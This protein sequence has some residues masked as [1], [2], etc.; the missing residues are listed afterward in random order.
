[1]SNGILNKIESL[2]PLPQ[3]IIEIENYR[4]E[5]CKDALK[6]LR[7]IE[8][9]ALVITTLLKTT[10]SAMFGFR[11]AVETPSR[12][13]NLLGINFTVSIAIASIINNLIKTD[14]EPYSL[15]GDDFMRLSNIATSLANIWLTK[16]DAELRD[17]LVLPALLQ[18][19]GK[20][21]IADVIAS[22]EKT[23][24]FKEEFT[25]T[26]NIPALEK[27]MSGY[28]T[29]EVTALVFEHWK[30]SEKLVSSIKYVDDLENCDP[31]YLQQ[32]QILDVIKTACDVRDPL[33][34]DCVNSA[35]KKAKTYGLDT[36][37]F[38]QAVVKLQERLLDEE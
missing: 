11:S 23:E 9:D 34:S 35:M 13:I 2:P 18:E 32:A 1:M 24:P 26:K 12:A 20:F 4:K 37:L 17:E 36:Q 19:A 31:E 6:L 22:N 25:Q 3:T 21:I 7:I 14:L 30:L 8:K 16:L 28:T 10:N 33:G 5:D 38:Y 15:S 29:S 27:E